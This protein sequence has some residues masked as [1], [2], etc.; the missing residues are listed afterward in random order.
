MFPRDLCL[1]AQH[2]PSSAGKRRYS[3]TSRASVPNGCSAFYPVYITS[4]VPNHVWEVSLRNLPFRVF[5]ESGAKRGTDDVVISRSLSISSHLLFFL[6]ASRAR[7][8]RTRTQPSSCHRARSSRR[9][10]P[11]PPPKPQSKSSSSSSS[12]ELLLLIEEYERT[13][14]PPPPTTKTTVRD[15][16]TTTKSHQR[17]PASTQKMFGCIV[18]GRAGIL[19][20]LPPPLPPPP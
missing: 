13:T 4:E 7:A 12:S 1:P 9:D 10:F 20:S 6:E 3:P 5:W 2:R 18:A 14:P 8:Q 17:R 19:P 16:L 15:Q 11:P